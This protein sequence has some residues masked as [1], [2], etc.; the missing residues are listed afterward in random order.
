MNG[1]YLVITVID[2]FVLSFMG[3][4][5][6]LSESLNKKQKSGFLLAF[7]LIAGISVM[8]IVTLVVDGALAKYRWLNIAANFLGFGL[9]PVVTICL[10]Y[11]QD[12]KAAP[13]RKPLFGLCFQI[14]TLP[15]CSSRCCVFGRENGDG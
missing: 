15:G 2:I 13:R 8:E 14:C 9:F 5:T 11:V 10:V 6:R 1:Y 7:V 12:K 4:L 3:I